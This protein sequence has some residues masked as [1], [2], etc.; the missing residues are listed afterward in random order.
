MMDNYPVTEK[1]NE[2]EIKNKIKVSQNENKKI[3]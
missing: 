2:K 1:I 3:N